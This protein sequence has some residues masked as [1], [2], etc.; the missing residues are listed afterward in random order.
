[1]QQQLTVLDALQP[2]GNHLPAKR[3]GQANHR[4]RQGQVVMVV[5]NVADER[6]VDLDRLRAQAL[7]VA[8]RRVTGA[9]VAQ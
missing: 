8:Q 4:R 3:P 9:E 1:L 6:P 2:L 5:Q 7:E